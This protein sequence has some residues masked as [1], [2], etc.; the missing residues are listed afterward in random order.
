[1]ALSPTYEWVSL[2]KEFILLGQE[3]YVGE[4]N[5]EIYKEYENR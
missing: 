2:G 5:P 3:R 4:F 1:M